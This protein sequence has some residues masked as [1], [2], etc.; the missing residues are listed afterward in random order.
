MRK[1]GK[2]IPYPNEF[3]LGKHLE[4]PK[5]AIMKLFAIVVHLG[6][7]SF[8]GHYYAFVRVGATWYKVPFP[9][10]RWTTPTSPSAPPRPS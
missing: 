3:D 4:N 8:S 1:I 5:K 2:H 6:G 10:L 7:S 9:L